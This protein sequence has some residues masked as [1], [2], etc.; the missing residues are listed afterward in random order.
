MNI[1]DDATCGFGS[2]TGA[3]GQ[4]IGDSVNPEVD[5]NGLLYNGGPTLTIGLQLAARR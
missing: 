5:P 3:N 1:S 4:T 2:G